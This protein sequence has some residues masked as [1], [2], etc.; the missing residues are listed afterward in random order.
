MDIDRSPEL[1]NY[2]R[3]PIVETILG[4]QFEP[5]LGL[6]NAHLGAFWKTLGDDWPT[7]ADAA[8]LEPQF[9]R[10][11]PGGMWQRMGIQLRLMENPTARLQIKNRDNDRMIQV[12]NGRLHFNW[13]GES[14]GPYPRYE[15]VRQDALIA[16]SRFE[17]Y[18]AREGLGRL[19]ANQWEITYVNHIPKGTVWETPMDWAFFLPLSGVGRLAASS[20][21]ESFGGEWHLEIPRQQGRL[22]V[23]WRHG[24]RSEPKDSEVV[25]LTFTARGGVP[26][27]AEG[28]AATFAGLDLGRAAIVRSFRAMMS[29]AANY[30]W[31]LENA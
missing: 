25:I 28:L 14:G 2:L 8:P 1:P 23:E 10:F 9:E 26:P 11:E 20:P 31:G 29:D 24:K 3:P 21:M 15:A 18:I 12:Q 22:H 17:G 30:Y 27:D 7:V 13:L 5:L 19:R 4:V 16:S 6:H